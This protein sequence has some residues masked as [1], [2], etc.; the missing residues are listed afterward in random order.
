MH[1][2]SPAVATSMAVGAARSVM[3]QDVEGAERSLELAPIGRADNSRLP[4]NGLVRAKSRQV[5]TYITPLGSTY[6]R[7]LLVRGE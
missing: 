6:W 5:R 3:A 1:V 7:K 2:T 4:T